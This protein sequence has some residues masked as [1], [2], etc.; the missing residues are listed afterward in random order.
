M[1]TF[2]AL[3]TLLI[4]LLSTTSWAA[5]TDGWQLVK[6]RDGIQVYGRDHQHSK[7]REY[8]AE[9][10]IAAELHQLLGVMNDT[11]ACPQWM[12]NCLAPALLAE[13]NT[14]ERYTYMR[15][16]LPWPYKDR[17]L[18]VRSLITPDIEGRSVSIALQGI[19][20][21]EL[22]APAQSALPEREKYPRA[23]SFLG[24]FQFTPVEQGYRVV[25]QL[26]IDLGGSPSASLANG[27]IADT[28]LKTLAG[29][30][31]I[32]SADKYRQFQIPIPF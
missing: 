27:Q 28:P 13:P 24:Q 5:D 25:Y 18:I 26:H 31:R 3:L 8:R 2:P 19:S 1:T 22:P 7:Y 23:D 12:H 16:D 15:N 30:R 20:E 11:D 21:A 14:L 32:V 4:G 6:D 17:A 29:M 9:T 10:V